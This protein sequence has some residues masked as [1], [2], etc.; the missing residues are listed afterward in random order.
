MLPVSS[1]ERK[2]ANVGTAASA[3]QPSEAKRGGARDGVLM[4]SLPS[5]TL[6]SNAH[7]FRH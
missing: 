4:E 7:C 2:Q 3:V 1:L 5:P 6:H